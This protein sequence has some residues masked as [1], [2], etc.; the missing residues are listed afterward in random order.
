MK[1]KLLLIALFC[2]SPLFSIKGFA[3]ELAQDQNPNYRNSMH[4]YLSV[5]DSLTKGEG[6]TFQDTYKAYDWFEAK[7]ERKDQRRLWRHEL[8]M[9]KAKYSRNYY[10]GYSG[11]YYNNYYAN[12]W[13]NNWWRPNVGFR[14]GNWWFSI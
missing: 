11:G 10:N 7:Q 1:G 9:E 12:N 2:V 5:A 6:T 4:Y 13:A 14:T 3:Q 8:R